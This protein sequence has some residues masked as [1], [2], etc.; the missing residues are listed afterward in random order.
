MSMFTR[1]PHC[2]T[3]FRVTPQQLQVS[4]GQVRCGRCEKVFDAFSTLSSRLT[5]GS[6]GEG[7]A[8][9]SSTPPPRPP[10][11]SAQAREAPI[12]YAFEAELSAERGEAPA[13]AVPLGASGATPDAAADIPG[14]RAVE[15]EPL[16]LGAREPAGAGGPGSASGL[17]VSKRARS[18]LPRAAS[19]AAMVL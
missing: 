19:G 18:A 5:D 10:A 1:C 9:E 14:R 13:A 7:D 11:A 8:A 3:V 15:P 17:S 2:D 4:S 16:T 12:D 6:I